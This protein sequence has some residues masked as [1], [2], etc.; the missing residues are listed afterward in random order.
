MSVDLSHENTVTLTGLSKHIPTRPHVSTIW[1]WHKV[2][3]RGRRLETVIV[4]G[5][6]VT[7]LEAFQRFADGLT[8]DRDGL[9]ATPPPRTSRQRRAAIAAAE[10]QLDAAGI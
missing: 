1:R 9:P 10:R 8:A 7:S 3:I 4:G 2:G 5:R 6:R